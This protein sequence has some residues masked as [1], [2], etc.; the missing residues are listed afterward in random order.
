R[1]LNPAENAPLSVEDIEEE[2]LSNVYWKIP[3]SGT[4][5]AEDAASALED[6]WFGYLN[7]TNGP[8]NLVAD[9]ASDAEQKEEFLPEDGD[10]RA[11]A[12]RQIKARRGR[13]AFRD[14]L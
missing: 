14:S 6:L 12:F 2:P 8:G 4:E 10:R 5:L 1:I 9:E 11:L 13:K 3:A 7:E